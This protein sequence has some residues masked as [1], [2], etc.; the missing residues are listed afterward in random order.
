MVD[1]TVG[2]DLVPGYVLH[3][4]FLCEGPLSAFTAGSLATGEPAE[5]WILRD[6]AW[7]G[8]PDSMQQSKVRA[9]LALDHPTL[10]APRHALRLPGLTAFILGRFEGSTLESVLS[11]QP[12]LSSR[13]VAQIGFDVAGALSYLQSQKVIRTEISPSSIL[14]G[15][16]PPARLRYTGLL[17]MARPP[18][19]SQFRPHVG[20]QELGRILYRAATGQE[21]DLA[22][23][24][25]PVAL[26]ARAWPS[27]ARAIRRLCFSHQTPVAAPEVVAEFKGL[28][29]TQQTT[30]FQAP[31]ATPIPPRPARR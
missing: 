5:L 28:L 9:I 7:Q 21:P 10:H 17:D 4:C 27:L 15:A 13:A 22:N 29:E 11:R 2:A 3:Q 6:A 1:E 12:V 23:Y 19:L 14:V 8:A 18:D 25:D 31:K 30:S 20:I 24:V 26:N 16:Q